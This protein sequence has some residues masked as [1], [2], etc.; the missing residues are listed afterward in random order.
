MPRLKSWNLCHIAQQ[1]AEKK[2]RGKTVDENKKPVE[3]DVVDLYNALHDA[4][5]PILKRYKIVERQWYMVWEDGYMNE[6]SIPKLEEEE[7]IRVVAAEV[8]KEQPAGEAAAEEKKDEKAAAAPKS[9][10][11]DLEGDF[12]LEDLH[13]FLPHQRPEDAIPRTE[14]LAFLVV[15]KP[16]VDFA[17]TRQDNTVG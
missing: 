6:W 13:E 17:L 11:D 10:L 5:E 9:N 1:K 7:K 8:D 15:G 16:D 3:P 12:G 14:V 4:I 2:L